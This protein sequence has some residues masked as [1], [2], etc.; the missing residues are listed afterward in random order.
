MNHKS[1]SGPSCPNSE[2]EDE[3]EKTYPGPIRGVPINLIAVGNGFAAIPARNRDDER[4]HQLHDS[5]RMVFRTADELGSWVAEHFGSTTSASRK[6]QAKPK[7]RKPKKTERKP[8]A[9]R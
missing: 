9:F 3:D 2:T 8:T 5:E 4:F 6:K 7:A 1:H